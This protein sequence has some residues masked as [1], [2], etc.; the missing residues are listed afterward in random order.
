[1]YDVV[2]LGESL[3]DCTPA[4][5]NDMG[6]PM[7]SCNPGGAPANVLAMNARLGG[8]TAFIGKVGRDAF[9]EFLKRTMDKAGVDTRG[10]CMSGEY[11][12][13]LAFVQLNEKG[14]RSF[15][16]YRKPGADVMLT[17]GEVDNSLLMSC[18]IFHFGSVSLTDE[19]CRTATL[20]AVRIAKESG[21]LISYDPNYRPALWESPEKAKEILTEAVSLADLLKVS[22]EEMTLITGEK[23]LETGTKKLAAMGPPVV[24]V[25]MGENGSY[26]YTPAGCGLLPAYPVK[27]VDTTG[28]GDAFLGALHNCIQKKSLHE[29][30]TMKRE[31]WVSM[32]QFANAAG[33]LTASKKGAIPAMPQRSEMMALVHSRV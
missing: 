13:T 3:I 11:K 20:Q 17:T 2:A 23:D 27:A 14:D 16:F 9:G 18:K 32:M 24:L 1:M 15:S 22:D 31:E 21:A 29:L 19:P 28:A 33:G 30:V 8:K 26:F 7:F 12:T 4:G 6:M 5:I 25:T 10:L